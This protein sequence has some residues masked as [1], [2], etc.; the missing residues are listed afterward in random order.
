MMTSSLRRLAGPLL[1]A[2]LPA[3]FLLLAAA[4]PPTAVRAAAAAADPAPMFVSQAGRLVVP[5][6]SPLRQRLQVAD[7][8]T[9][10]GRRV[11]AVPAVVEADPARVVAIVPPLAGRLV[12]LH[13]GLGDVVRRGQPLATVSSPDFGQAMADADKAADALDLAERALRRARGVQA[14]GA[15]A[16]KDL[17]AAEAARRDAA[18]EDRRARDRVAALA[19]GAKIDARTRALVVAAPVSGTVTALN[20]GVGAF[21]ND[22]TAPLMTVAGLDRV[23]VTA[24]VP[25]QALGSIA[26]GAAVDVSLAAFPGWTL[27]GRAMRASPVLE[28][29]TRRAKV[30]IAFDNADGRLRPNMFA[31]ASFAVPE[32]GGV[33]VPPSALLM[34]N[35][36]TTVLVEVAPWTFARREVE[37]GAEDE[38]SVRIVSGLKRGDRVVVRGG[39]LLDD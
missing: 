33:T 7:V 24:L 16:G 32:D 8:G 29:D 3:A 38:R 6:G 1:S 14:A 11:L 35:D 19:G 22:A 5:A 36:S 17:E 31:T 27:H 25:E 2:A 28:P 37:T 23:F 20:A 26:P 30:R 9:Q 10:P 4:V 21:L 12:A 34:N 18:V 39:V 13:V 15:N